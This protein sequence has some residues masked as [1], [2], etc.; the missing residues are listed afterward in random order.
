[1]LSKY[2]KKTF[3]SLLSAS[4]NNKREKGGRKKRVERDEAGRGRRDGRSRC[5]TVRQ[6]VK[7]S[8]STGTELYY[9]IIF[10]T[11]IIKYVAY[12]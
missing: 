3:S 1:M 12:I 9:F 7:K 8:D 6:A 5:K 11:H 4:T 10:H 2:V